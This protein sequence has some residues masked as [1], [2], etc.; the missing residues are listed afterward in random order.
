MAIY[1]CKMCGGDLEIGENSSVCICQY[2][3]T[4][5]TVPRLD[6][7]KKANLFSRANRLRLNCEFDRAYG[8][9]ESIIAECP[10]EAEAYWGL[11]LC[12]YGIE[13]VDDPK[14]ARKIPTCHR[15]SFDSVFDDPNYDLTLE[16][17]IG[18]A[19]RLYREEAKV[20]E[21][22][23]KGIIEISSREEPYD[24]F[25]CY[26]EKDQRGER[27]IDS[28]IA[29][30]VYEA[31]CDKGYRVFFSRI[32]LEDKIGK[33]YEPYIFSALHSAKIMLVFGTD[34]EHF[35][36]VWV[37]NEWSRFLKLMEE[38][39]ERALIPCFKDIDIYD[40]PREFH[41]LQAQDMGKV[42]AMQ[43]LL[44]GI[45][46]II[47]KPDETKKEPKEPETA[48]SVFSKP[49][50]ERGIEL[51]VSRQFVKAENFFDK[52][53]EYEPENEKALVGKLLSKNEVMSIEELG[54]EGK[55][56]CE[57]E[58]FERLRN[59]ENPEINVMLDACLER[60]L[61]VGLKKAQ[62]LLNGKSFYMAKQEYKKIVSAYPKN[63]DALLGLMLA[64]LGFSNLSKLKESC[65]EFD[66]NATFKK[67]IAI[68]DDELKRE[69]LSCRE[70]VKNNV[71]ESAKISKIAAVMLVSFMVLAI[72]IALIVSMSGCSAS[73]D[74]SN[75]VVEEYGEG[76]TI[77]ELNDSVE[78]ENGH[79]EIPDE[80][81]GKAVV[82]IKEGAFENNKEIRSVTIYCEAT[83]K[84]NGW[85]LYWNIENRP[86]VWGYS[87]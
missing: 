47:V 55:G 40:M 22:L 28:V 6:S 53:L 11:V 56:V 15:S 86:V 44:R 78:F 72:V 58:L 34:Y 38:D 32:S 80:I 8:V 43:D 51:L 41:K 85:Y 71:K 35:N 62:T 70:R 16:N 19:S 81:D 39:S 84:P 87:E 3:G 48:L 76:Y 82:G 33:E 59:L 37:K 45:E 42:G 67:L 63:Q 10:E 7:E 83:S 21:G 30:D 77:T 14:T 25:I 66:A 12:K 73:T 1:K 20:I 18:E 13:Y 65:V 9:Y 50:L 5:Q 79:L 17:S 64:E 26:K 57:T 27:T 69:L 75:F 24:I 23:R 46:K 4:Q 54:V 36:A 29:Q 2:C 60:T 61:E 74:E 49:L 68:C 52:A 31:L